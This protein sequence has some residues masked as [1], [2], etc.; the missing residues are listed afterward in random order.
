MM[1]SLNLT[2][3][4]I[5]YLGPIYDKERIEAYTAADIFVLTSRAYE[6]TSL[7]SLEA[8]ASNTPVILTKQAADYNI[9]KYGAGTIIN[10]DEKQLMNALTR[11]LDDEQLRC[12]M[13][14]K[15]RKMVEEVF[16]VSK[17]V[18]NFETVLKDCVYNGFN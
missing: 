1:R 11:L 7:A 9:I 4:K 16:S 13:G 17:V 15:S 18:I 8:C 10:F 12:E 2:E 6:E 5:H 3:E 14:I